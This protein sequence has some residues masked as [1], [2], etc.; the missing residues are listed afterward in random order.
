MDPLALVSAG[1]GLIPGFVDLF[2]P[3]PARPLQPMGRV[4][5]PQRRSLYQQ[6]Q[7]PPRGH[8]LLDG[9][10]SGGLGVLGS[11]AEDP[12]EK[13]MREYARALAAGQLRGL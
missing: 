1:I 12:M 13:A 6:P 3:A 10:L 7:G 4:G 5:G 11:L 2:T 9:V 8:A